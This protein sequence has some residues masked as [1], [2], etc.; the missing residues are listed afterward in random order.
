MVFRLTPAQGAKDMM[1]ERTFIK[2]K[3]A[4]LT[5]QL[6][7]RAWPQLWPDMVPT[8]MQL[9]NVGVCDRSALSHLLNLLIEVSLL[10]LPHTCP[11]P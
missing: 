11:I 2:E 9:A 10:P 1:V 6:A 4:D 7:K 5:V 3:I 8:L